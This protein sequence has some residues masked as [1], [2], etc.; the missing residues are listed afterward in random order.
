MA[1]IAGQSVLG[2]QSPFHQP[3]WVTSRR[4]GVRR[5]GNGVGW[6]VELDMWFFG[7]YTYTDY[8]SLL[9]CTKKKKKKK[10]KQ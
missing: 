3:H 8:V 1:G 2:F 7:V 4:Y 6:G 9:G 10:K 5:A